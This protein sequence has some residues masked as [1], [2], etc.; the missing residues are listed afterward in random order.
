M[1]TEFKIH[2]VAVQNSRRSS[3]LVRSF[4]AANNCGPRRVPALAGTHTNTQTDT[5]THRQTHTHTHTHTHTQRQWLLS[6]N[7]HA[8]THTHL[9]LICAMNPPIAGSLY[10]AF[11]RPFSLL[12][13]L[14][15]PV[16][17]GPRKSIWPPVAVEEHLCP[18]SSSRAVCVA[19]PHANPP[20]FIYAPSVINCPICLLVAFFLPAQ[21]QL[22]HADW[23]SERGLGP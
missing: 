5:Q 11:Y 18:I 3:P 12:L 9:Q 1:N 13:L 17:R 7:T 16:P 10:H 22:W 4:I 14:P 21:Y 20:V 23:S 15:A 2:A 8:H 19:S 6:T